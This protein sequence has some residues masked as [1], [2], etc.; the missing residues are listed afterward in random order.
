MAVSPP[1]DRGG[2]QVR[3]YCMPSSSGSVERIAVRDPG[4]GPLET[5]RAYTVHFAFP[6]TGDQLLPVPMLARPIARSIE[7]DGPIDYLIDVMQM[8]DA[9]AVTRGSTVSGYPISLAGFAEAMQ[10]VRASCNI[11]S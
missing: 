8:Q 7:S 4:I 5:N 6:D 3:Y 1:G 2:V 11:R 10:R 9:M